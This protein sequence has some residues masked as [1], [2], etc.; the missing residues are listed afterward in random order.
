MLIDEY[1]AIIS[2]AIRAFEQL[3]NQGYPPQEVAAMLFPDRL[4]KWPKTLKGPLE[5]ERKLSTPRMNRY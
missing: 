3:E 1:K 2:S 5:D 4:S